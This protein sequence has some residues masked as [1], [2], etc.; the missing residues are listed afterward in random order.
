MRPALEAL[1]SVKFYDPFVQHSAAEIVKLAVAD[2]IDEVKDKDNIAL[3][4]RNL[5]VRKLK[6][7]KLWVM[8]A[9]DILN[10]T[11]I[12][13]LYDG[14]DFEG[15]ETFAE[16]KAKIQIHG[17]RIQP[18]NSWIEALNSNDF[19][20]VE[21]ASYFPDVNVISKYRKYSQNNKYS[22]IIFQMFL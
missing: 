11:K 6:S 1:S 10:L 7:A 4:T 22:D 14:L 16:L 21:K 19:I 18:Q 20:R 3:E 2:V 5:I 17:S 13:E 15:S 9:D 12:E 8:F